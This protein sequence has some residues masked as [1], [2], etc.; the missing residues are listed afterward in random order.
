[1]TSG[2]SASVGRPVI[3][4]VIGG[5]AAVAVFVL[6]SL[7]LLR[8]LGRREALQNAQEFAELVGHGIVEPNLSAPLLRR[9]RVAIANIDRVVQERVLGERI[10]RVKLWTPDGRIVYSDE[11]RLIGTR[12][13]LEADKLETLR[14][15]EAHVEVSD[16]RAP[17]N[18]FERG[19][20]ALHE[21]YTRVRAPGGVPLLFETYQESD[22]VGTSS[23]EI[24]LPFAVPLLA[25]LLLLWLTQVPLA[26]RLA[27]RLRE[28]Q[29][30]RES[31]LVHALEA[32]A[33]ERRRIASDLHDGPVQ[34]LAGVAYSLNAT[35]ARVPEVGADLEH[36]ASATRNAIRQL[37]S[38]LVAIHPPNLRSAG[39]ASAL[40][41]LVA[42]LH[43]A[44]VITQLDVPQDLHVDAGTEMLLFRAAGEAVRNVERHARAKHV[45]VSVDDTDGKVR[46]EVADD[47]TGFVPTELER[48]RAEGHVGL[49]LL[50]QLVT[51]AGGTLQIESSPGHGTLLRVEVPR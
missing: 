18:R 26:W 20:D 51:R 40:K 29:R 11:P 23:R 44:G 1:M 50:E 6:G 25:S 7:L 17:E 4:F 14:S 42:P 12:Y 21:V 37:R 8:E 48:R 35:A 10:V 2:D 5:L 49:S 32:S 45:T 28:A 24:W 16:L 39:L 38:V 9:D 19:Y 31:L 43:A 33:D 36:A 13:E 34:G 41:D 46:L 22:S 3:Q 27:H 15:G 30:E 47:G